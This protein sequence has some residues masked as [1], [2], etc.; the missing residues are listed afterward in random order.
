MPIWVFLSFMFAQVVVAAVIVALGYVNV[1]IRSISDTVFNSIANSLVYGLAIATALGVPYLIKRYKTSLQDLGLQRVVSWSDILLVAPGAI[2]YIILTAALAAL[3]AALLT[4]VDYNQVQ[5]TGFANLSGYLEFALAFI[6]LVVVA[7]VAEEVLFRGYLFG[8]MRQYA[9]LWVA[10]L[11]TSLLFAVVHFQWNVG[12]DVF[13]LSLVLCIL[14]V[15]S[16]SLWP[17]IMLHMLK[18]GV[19]FYFLFINPI[20][21]STI[22]G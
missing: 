9:P 13:A 3:A 7:P 18:N 22:G 1:P 17:S 15:V 11:L 5:D 12:I 16:G 2:V 6:S 19:A 20:A 21:L 8:K 4:F 14:R 10:V